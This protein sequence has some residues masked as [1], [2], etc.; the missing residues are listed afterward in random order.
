MASVEAGLDSA[1]NQQLLQNEVEYENKRAAK[2]AETA[3]AKAAAEDQDGSQGVKA[4]R[5]RKP[6]AAAKDQGT[7]VTT[8][9]LLMR[10]PPHRA[11]YVAPKPVKGKRAP[12]MPMYALA[13]WEDGPGCVPVTVLNTRRWPYKE[14]AAACDRG[15]ISPDECKCPHCE[16]TDPRN[17]LSTASQGEH[18]V[19]H[20]KYREF[21][22]LRKEKFPHCSDKMDT[23][24]LWSQEHEDWM[25]QYLVEL[26]RVVDPSAPWFRDVR[27]APS[28]FPQLDA[29]YAA[30]AA[31]AV[32]AAHAAAAA[33]LA[34]PAP[35]T[36]FKSGMRT[37]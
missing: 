27:Y 35:A 11:S 17:V 20:V 21:H 36:P 6:K 29:A 14:Y 23:T 34:L 13:L 12:T 19:W 2:A 3:R 10:R 18:V 32:A 22:K 9:L 15:S 7:N 28:T 1:S 5:S 16:N 37:H 30:R 8:V 31:A 4:R 24:T 26:W 25:L 33:V